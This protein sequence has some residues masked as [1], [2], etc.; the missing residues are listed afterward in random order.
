MKRKALTRVLVLGATGMLGHK[1]C[2]V[3]NPTFDVTGT[4]RGDYRDIT[5]YKFFEPSKIVLHLD[6]MNIAPVEKV[7]AKTEPDVVINCI[8]VVKSLVEKTDISTTTWLNAQFPHELYRICRDKGVRLIHVSTDCVF[9]GKKGN[10][11]ENS[12]ADAEDVYGQTKYLGEVIGAGSLTIRT[13]IIGRELTGANGLVEWFLA[14]KGGTVQGYTNA[15]FSGFPTLH[16]SR[17]IAN[18]ITKHESLNGVYNVSSEPI[19]KFK[20][21]TLI[22]KAF[23][24]NI[25]IKEYPGVHIDRSLNSAR[26]R[27]E[28]GFTPL[29]WKTMVEELAQDASSYLKWR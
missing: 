15:I 21:L 13:S 8:G 14:N 2:Q 9:S 20:L 26:F 19:S 22:K 4:I 5:K 29:P 11:N 10:Y 25:E 12:R 7:I 17:I 27:E 1:L 18:V 6:A 3:L 28:T 16:L 24:L 23:G